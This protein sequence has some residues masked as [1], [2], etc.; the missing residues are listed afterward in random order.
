MARRGAACAAAGRR[1]TGRT[2]PSAFHVSS[3]SSHFSRSSTTSSSAVFLPTPLMRV[4]PATSSRAISVAMSRGLEPDRIAIAVLGPTFF[5]RDQQ[6]E[7]R[8]LR[9]DRRSRTA[10][11]RFSR[12]CVNTRSTTR[13]P[14][15]GSAASVYAEH[16]DL[17]ADA[18]AV[19]DHVRA[20][21]LD[22]RALEPRDHGRALTAGTSR[23]AIGRSAPAVRDRDRERIGG[24]GAR[25]AAQPDQRL[26]HARDLRLVGAARAATPSS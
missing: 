20:V 6:I 15:A 18:A 19:D 22:Q 11:S 12:A 14:S 1:A 13:S 3:S 25:Q 9:R 7:Q 5:D 17:V 21:A 16:I 10:R 24:V 26:H 4:S 2:P 8:A 23:A